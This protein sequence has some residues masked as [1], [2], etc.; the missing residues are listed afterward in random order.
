[1]KYVGLLLFSLTFLSNCNTVNAVNK[2][3]ESEKQSEE[4]QG[5]YIVN[6]LYGQDVS[7]HKITMNFNIQNKTISGFSGCNTYSCS[8]TKED[9]SFSLGFPMASKRYCEQ[10]ADLEKNFF[11][12]LS[13]LKTSKSLKGD[14]IAFN[15]TAEKEIIVAKE[16]E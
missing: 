16:S 9:T 15:N 12:A 6:T 4:L 11:K 1:M 3:G 7:E 2:N 5:T 8:Y 14:F 10:I 13:E